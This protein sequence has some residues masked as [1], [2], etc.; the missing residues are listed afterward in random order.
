[1]ESIL[2]VK[3]TE[4]DF[5]TQVLLNRKLDDRALGFIV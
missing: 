3:K 1:M 5:Y 4:M 2:K